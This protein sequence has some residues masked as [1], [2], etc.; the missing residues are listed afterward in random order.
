MEGI[1]PIIIPAAAV[2][3]LIALLL[4]F[5]KTASG[6]EALV[7]SGVGATDKDGNPK[8]IRAGGC[9][10][11]PFLQQY[12]RFDCCIRTTSVKGDI[13]KTRTGVPIRL[14]WAVEYGP[15]A[16]KKESLQKAVCHFLDKDEKE[17]E[18]VVLDIVSGGVRAVIAQMSPV[19]VMRE[20]DQL[21][22]K[23]KTS[24]SNEMAGL[25]LMVT[26]SIHEVD[27]ADG[28]TYF[29]DLAAEDRESK[30]RDA[31]NFTAEA[32]RSIREK[33]AE[34]NRSASEAEL[35][36]QVAIAEKQRDADVKRA[37]F[38][39]ETDRRKVE[40][41]RAGELQQEEIN[42]EL[43][44]K[45][46]AVEIER[47]KQA[48]LAAQAAQQV[49]VTQAETEKKSKI[50]AAEAAAETKKTE[51]EGEAAADATRKTRAA[52]A[53]A[54]A[55]KTQAG[56]DAEAVR[57]QAEADASATKMKGEAEAAAIA[58]KG[59]AEAEAIEAKG[60][61]E[62]EAA[63]KLSE[64]QAAN[65][66][67]NFELRSLEIEQNARVQIATNVATVMAEVGKQAKFIDFGGGGKAEGGDLLTRVLSGI[68]QLFARADA[69]NEALNGEG[70]TDTLE[71]LVGAVAR[72]I[73]GEGST[74]EDA[75]TPEIEA[76]ADDEVSKEPEPET[77]AGAPA[78]EDE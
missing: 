67:V 45:Q 2:V 55:K 15:E 21:D 37:E 54:T 36:A 49:A 78:P 60:K 30:R 39:A 40:A 13:T 57:V 65:D 18:R 10:V 33:E 76:A 66:R 72:P 47:Q 64:A 31:A 11:W 48:N 41:D 12:K 23:V 69:Q 75:A 62:A 53:A 46:G 4:I 17:L 7:V 56:A 61:A 71:R 8:I 52:E 28:S 24:I 27:D 44:T 6:N 50:I 1:L 43:A 26:L 63:L 70:L 73:K 38:K 29:Q 77:S 34:T 9:I 22:D 35:S 3:V 59:R 5:I 58:A 68:P 74:A 19:E 20:K 25:G 16:S 51:A 32:Q 42:R 14:D